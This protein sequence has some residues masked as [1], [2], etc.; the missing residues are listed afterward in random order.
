M[1]YIKEYIVDQTLLKIGSEFIRLWVAIRP[2]NKHIIALNVSKE[3]NMF[4]GE[5]LLSDLVPVYGKTC[6]SYRWQYMAHNGLSI[7]KSKTPFS[8]LLCEDDH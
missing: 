2:E 5:V 6:C 1:E 8:Y 4:I 7:P 3:R